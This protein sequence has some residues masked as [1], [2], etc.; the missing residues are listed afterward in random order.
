MKKNTMATLCTPSFQMDKQLKL[1]VAYIAITAPTATMLLDYAL[2]QP[3]ASLMALPVLFSAMFGFL[4][5]GH[6]LAL[7]FYIMDDKR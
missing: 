2:L 6:A 1:Y 7:T 5:I 3:T 4:A